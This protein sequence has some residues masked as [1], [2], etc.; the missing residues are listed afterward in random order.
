MKR[1]AVLLALACVAVALAGGHTI[2]EATTALSAQGTPGPR[3]NFV[4][5]GD[6]RHYI[7][8]VQPPAF[9]R[10]IDEINVLQ[11]ELAVDIGDL[12][13]GY[14]KDDAVTNRMW[15]AY[16]KVVDQSTVP[17]FS[18]VGNHDV[19]TPAHE[20]IWKD[21]LGPTY[22]S[23]TYGRA[24]FL[25]L[26]SNEATG[27]GKIGPAQL[28]WAR[29]QLEAA[30]DAR[31]L[32]VFLHEPLWAEDP[33]G[34][35][36]VH[37]LLK[38][39]PAVTKAVFAGHWHVYNKYPDRDGIQYTI[40]GGGGAEIGDLSECGDFHHYL[41]VQ[42][43][44]DRASWSVVRPGG[45]DSPDVV[46][47]EQSARLHGL[48][49]C[50]GGFE[51]VGEQG[52]ASGVVQL[53]LPVKNTTKSPLRLEV[54]WDGLAYCDTIDPEDFAT[55]VP[56]GVERTF[57]FSLTAQSPILALRNL[58]CLVTMPYGEAGQKLTVRRVPKFSTAPGVHIPQASPAAPEPE[59]ESDAQP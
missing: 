6:S 50:L 58:R 55:Q 17:F 9:L 51:A 53:K 8:V 4:V 18:V 39:H 29:N 28:E 36:A 27:A 10:T 49:S 25:C 37:D 21:R 14:T 38:A 31:L 13:L 48:A 23:F 41:F 59:K 56:P 3:W 45:I 7:P 22:F 16:F 15:D 44:G 24:F 35:Q 2:Q 12:I 43:N 26:D 40:T 54:A 11:P 30:K 52:L 1:L 33:K 32:F 57:E 47:N 42:V 5:L 20:K 46:T 34:W 19:S